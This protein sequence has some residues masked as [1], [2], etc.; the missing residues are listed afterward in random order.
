MRNSGFIK[1]DRRIADSRWFKNINTCHLFIYLL[2]RANYEEGVFEM[3]NI[4]RGQLVTS[5]KQL[6][7]DTGL[8]FQQVRTALKHLKSTHDI[9]SETTTKYT[10]ITVK[11]Y[12]KYAASTHTLTNKQHAHNKVATNNQQQYNKNNKKKKNNKGINNYPYE[13]D[14]EY[15]TVFNS[16]SKFKD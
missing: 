2:L 3:H 14:E 15:F 8:S 9:T 12:E 1:L 13:T 4:K 5:L 6:S 16:K 11:D 10:I 7:D